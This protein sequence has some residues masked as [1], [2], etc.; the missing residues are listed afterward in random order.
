MAD[1]YFGPAVAARYD[2]DSERFGSAWLEAE[3][4]FLAELAGAGGTALEFAIGT[5]RV[6]LPLAARGVEVAGIDLSESMVDQLRA[7]LRGADLIVEIGDFT[8]ARVAGEFDLVYLVYN[9]IGNVTTQD[10][11]VGT[12]PPSPRRSY[13][14]VTSRILFTCDAES[15]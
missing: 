8:S 4:S 13:R 12:F 7:K 15:H 14:D 5:G 11:Q 9:T 10:G 2:D 3:T 1:D 6:A